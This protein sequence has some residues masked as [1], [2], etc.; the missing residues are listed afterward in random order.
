[1][2]ALANKTLKVDILIKDVDITSLMDIMD[3]IRAYQ[4]KYTVSPEDNID[5]D[6]DVNFEELMHHVISEYD[7]LP[8]SMEP[9]VNDAIE[10][11][12][13]YDR[14]FCDKIIEKSNQI[15]YTE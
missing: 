6:N 8:I 12:E 4:L 13:C 1:M 7:T 14:E 5:R 2:A 15:E 10:T 3:T 9:L 11:F